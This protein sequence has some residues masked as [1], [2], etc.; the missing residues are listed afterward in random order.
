MRAG[1][2]AHRS[3]AADFACPRQAVRPYWGGPAADP[4]HWRLRWIGRVPALKALSL[5]STACL[6]P[7]AR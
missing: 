5:E 4:N 3:A 7:A 6:P 1:L 2:A